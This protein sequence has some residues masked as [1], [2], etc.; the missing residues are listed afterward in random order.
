MK[1]VTQ[2]CLQMCLLA[3]VTFAGA[4]HAAP[5]VIIVK[6][7]YG[8]E[9]HMVDV[10]G[11]I[12]ASIAA[13]KYTIS[14]T[15]D[16]FQ[17]DPAPNVEKQLIVQYTLNGNAK[18]SIVAEGDSINL[19]NGSIVRAQATMTSL[20]V[21]PE[22]SAAVKP[23][24][25][26]THYACDD[27]AIASVVVTEPPFGAKGD[28]VTDCTTAVQTAID[29]V[30][31]AGGG[32]VFLPTGRY[33]FEGSLL[34]RP[35]VTLRGDWKAPGTTPDSLKV[36]GTVL[37]P[38]GGRG[39]ENG[40]PFIS[41]Q[42]GGCVRNLSI[43]YPDQTADAVA[44][45]PWAIS[46]DPRGGLDN[47]TV[48]N[49][50]LV[51]P[52]QGLR[53]GP[54]NNELSV[55]RNVYGT[56]LKTGYAMY[57]CSDSP[58]M[59]VLR[60]AAKYWIESGL[61]IRPD[62]AVVA[63]YLREHGTGLNFMRT[64]GHDLFD[65]SATG[66]H[67]GIHVFEGPN[68]QPYGGMYGVSA[69]GG[70]I[71]LLVDEVRTGWQ[72]TNCMFAGDTAGILAEKPFG[73]QL[74]LEHC[75]LAGRSAFRS[76]GSGSVQ[77]HSCTLMGNVEMPAKGVISMLNCSFAE[78]ADRLIIGRGV[79][80]ALVLGGIS[81]GAV[82]NHSLGDV[83]V[84]PKPVENSVPPPIPTLPPDPRPAKP[85]LFNVVDYG[86]KADGDS[87]LPTDNTQA[88]SKALDA[89][90][91]AGGG[92]AYVP[93]GVYLLAGS[94]T[95]P[96]GVELRG[97]FDAAHH[98]M[99]KGTV[100]FPTGGRGQ[101]DGTPFISLSTGSGARGLTVYYPQQ[102]VDQITPYPWT[103]RSLGPR[104]WLLD[105]A[106]TNAYRLADFGTN[107]SEGHLIRYV[108]G[109]PLKIGFWVSKGAGVVDGC[110]IN[111][112]FWMRRY[113]GAPSWVS[114]ASINDKDAVK[115][116]E[117]Q[118][119]NRQ[120]DFVFGSCP[121]ELMVNNAVCPGGVGLRFT[122]DNGK[123]G[124]A[125]VINH[126]SDSETFP[127][128]VE[129]ADKAGIALYNTVLAPISSSPAARAVYVTQSC[130]GNVLLCNGMTWGGTKEP[131]LTLL[132]SGKTVFHNWLLGQDDIVAGNGTVVL[133]AV[134]CA[135]SGLDDVQAAS[136]PPLRLLLNGNSAGSDTFTFPSAIW[137]D[138]RG[139][140][141]LPNSI[142]LT[143]QFATGF[144]PG[145]PA[146]PLNV[147]VNVGLATA[148]CQV[149]PG[150]GRDGSAGLVMTAT[151]TADAKHASLM[152]VIAT[153]QNLM[154]KPDTMLRFW[155]RPQTDM[156]RNCVVDLNCADG[157]YLR[158]TV[159]D[160]SGRSLH[161]MSQRGAIGK[162]SRFECWLGS[163]AAGKT[164]KSIVVI[165]DTGRPTGDCRCIFDDVEIGE[166]VKAV[167][168]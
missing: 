132:G 68:G 10:A 21:T 153:P 69:T 103:F 143:D 144:E 110:H 60:F 51:N 15:N 119:N 164:V 92:T 163:Y 124:S 91:K 168:R 40:I 73:T 86:A 49:V 30:A 122:S 127:L 71:G 46:T 76:E 109:L 138:A 83:Q 125:L 151:P 141:K 20:V 27:Y 121:N 74:Q 139:N 13:G 80:R 115:F 152:Y 99:S 63:A 29:A 90:A 72:L 53:F 8:A 48:E 100:L 39:Q 7:Q 11:L 85:L 22:A 158:D 120:E 149:T 88:F 5:A 129:A 162:W 70:D 67:I 104:C 137:I 47:F 25:V 108:M 160:T 131:A 32:V 84:D 105:V 2:Y 16:A 24:V 95:V 42:A 23:R 155:M 165:F 58:R 89:A 28:G 52:Y 14:A 166:P 156:G 4:S 62:A 147:I 6:A 3:M 98:T 81:P 116:L 167:E 96:S 102:K 101:D 114:S 35:A 133:H 140:G 1:F 82:E 117:D 57:T 59:T 94:L 26:T 128:R 130:A 118:M 161:P 123:V 148:N 38:A 154:V 36:A 66:Y 43:W 44:A 135:S 41:I 54:D 97:C 145:Q 12:S 64:D 126:E 56:P 87:D 111:P 159:P 134:Q 31:A 136:T 146:P 77:M 34:L 113:R 17:G 65:V 78:P 106:S 150:A 50:T 79:G 61:G 157:F 75:R 33:R 9:G 37:M 112:H 55:V 93:A 19:A 107:P 45:Y 18:K 142:P